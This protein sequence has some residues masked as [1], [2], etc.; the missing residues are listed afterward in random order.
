MAD[1]RRTATLTLTTND[2]SQPTASY[3]LSCTGQ[4]TAGQFMVYLPTISK[5][6]TTT[7]AS[8]PDLVASLNASATQVEVGQPVGVSVTI[9]NQ[10]NAAASEFWVDLYINPSSPPSATNQ[11]W[12]TRCQLDPC[13]GIAWYVTQSVAPGES[14]ILTSTAGSYYAANTIWNGTFAPGT[15]DLYAYVDSWNPTV[16]EGAV[17]ESNE[18]NNRAELHGLTVAG[19]AALSAT[20][21]AADLPLRPVHPNQ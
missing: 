19:T 20:S 5:A 11:P 13:Y 2:P 17:T 16:A 8:Q 15:T 12:N 6:A 3:A 21:S 1:R 4:A 10:G 9:T 14:I 7:L 18:A